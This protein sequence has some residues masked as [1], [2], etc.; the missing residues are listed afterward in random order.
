[1]FRVEIAQALREEGHDVMR[2]SECGQA[3]A[4]DR[5]IL[6][7]AIAENRI[8]ITLDEH[9]HHIHPLGAQCFEVD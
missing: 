3:R 1:M 4:D 8:L 7:K 5:E 6:H 9:T 2:A